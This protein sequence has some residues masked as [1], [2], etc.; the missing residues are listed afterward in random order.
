[1]QLERIWIEESPSREGWVRLSGQ[2]AYDDGAA[3]SELYW[4]EVPERL[5][6][7]L[8]VSGNPWLACLLPLAVTL[9]EPLRICQPVDGALL[10]G[11]QE[12]MQIW[13]CWYPH[14]RVVPVEAQTTNGEE[15]EPGSKTVAF[16]SGGVD[17][18]FTALRHNGVPEGD[19]PNS[20]DEFLYVWGFDIPLHKP[21]AYRRHVNRLRKAASDL[22]KE[23]VDVATNLKT[24]RLRQAEWGYLYHGCALASV[25]LSLEKRYGKVLIASSY[26]YRN[27][28]PWGSHP[29]TDPHLSTSRTKVVHD[30]AAFSRVEK[31][32]LVAES[33]VA[34]RSLHVC[35]R[36]ASDENCGACNKCYRTMTTLL[37]L[38]ALGRCSAF[39]AG[40]FKDKKIAKV[41][42]P[43]DNDR[44]FFREI[45]TLAIQ[46]G[47]LD[48]ARAIDRSFRRSDC[49]NVLL[50]I[51]RSLKGRP[52]V[53]RLER[54]L[55]AGL[56]A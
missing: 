3:P 33:D 6:D 12:L 11:V 31:T 54:A 21:D 41:Y 43:L 35:Y 8:T 52:F 20:I 26:G 9:G 55:L 56:K 34:M 45:R 53:W 48:V 46:K 36:V 30:G 23:L 47:R 28:H 25:A 29:L 5:V 32:K 2:V 44:Y 24:T 50:P 7:F 17:S 49:L 19:D 1:M 10:E 51:V 16:F 14:L 42:S 22:D 39:P 18:F 13:K 38:G 4:F 37:L 27:L 40:S 15:G